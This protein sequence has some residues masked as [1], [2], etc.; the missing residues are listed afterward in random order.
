MKTLI[1]KDLRENWKAALIGLLVFGLIL[2]QAVKVSLSSLDNL[3]SHNWSVQANVLQPVIC[4]QLL[5][6]AAF[7]CGLFGALLGWLQTRNEAHRDLWGFLIV[8]VERA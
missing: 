2:L 7:F 8:R 5:V 4:P 6:E 3:L 1:Q